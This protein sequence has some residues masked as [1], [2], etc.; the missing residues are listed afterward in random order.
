MG[1][2]NDTSKVVPSPIL[3]TVEEVEE[4]GT[5]SLPQLPPQLPIQLAIESK[6]ENAPEKEVE[7]LIHVDIESR[8]SGYNYDE[9]MNW[10]RKT[11]MPVR[12]K[13]RYIEL[14]VTYVLKIVFAVLFVAAMAFLGGFGAGF[15]SRER[16]YLP[17]KA[18]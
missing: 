6:L 17:V 8:P 4:D 5:P 2:K 10:Y 18:P 13:T 1:F 15:A 3:E 14:S 9:Y 7:G 16:L 11:Y 12:S